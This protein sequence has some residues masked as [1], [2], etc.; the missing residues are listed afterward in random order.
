MSIDVKKLE[1]YL[2]ENYIEPNPVEEKL[3]RINSLS[4]N[5]LVDFVRAI[6]GR[7][8][9]S[10]SPIQGLS[11]TKERELKNKLEETKYDD[12]LSKLYYYINLKGMTNPQVYKAAG[13]SPQCFGHINNR[14]TKLPTKETLLPIIFALRLTLDEAIDLL[15]SAELGLANYK[16]DLIYRFCLEEGDSLDEVNYYLNLYGFPTIGGVKDNKKEAKKNKN[17]YN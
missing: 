17:Q 8:S 1:A 13:V 12:F 10:L 5:P 16:Q 2:D 4:K 6:T 15:S 3:D 11:L 9:L 7:K 14:T